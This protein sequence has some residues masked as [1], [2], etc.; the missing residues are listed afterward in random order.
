MGNNINTQVRWLPPMEGEVSFFKEHHFM[1]ARMQHIMVYLF[2]I[3]KAIFWLGEMGM[4][5]VSIELG[6]KLVVDGILDKST[7][8]FKFG[9]IMCCR[10]FLFNYPNFKIN[11]V[12]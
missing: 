8:Q 9:K 4:S 10:M 11:F 6:C 5:N 2:R 3:T 7:K 1:K 12:R